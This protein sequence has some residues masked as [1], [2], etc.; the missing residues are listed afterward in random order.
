MMSGGKDKD[1]EARGFM[2]VRRP[3]FNT[4]ESGVVPPQ[5]PPR[6][7]GTLYC[8]IDRM[9]WNEVDL[10]FYE[11]SLP[12]D[13]VLKREVIWAASP[14]D[15]DFKLCSDLSD[16][17]ALLDFSN[18]QREE[19]ELAIVDSD[20]LA[21]YPAIPLDEVEVEWLGSDLYCHGFGSQLLGGIFSDPETFSEFL[22]EL[23][24]HGLFE[25]GTPTLQRYKE[26]Y[27]DRATHAGLEPIERVDQI[28]TVR[29][30]RVL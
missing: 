15:L 28:D 2:V 16:A 22:E 1:I 25:I 23:N 6:I 21:R 24:E 10:A 27:V 18:R 26:A 13:L 4:R 29:V 12:E 11:R 5:P 20:L 14:V 9:G 7:D 17:R 30:G 19:S 3:E 8:G